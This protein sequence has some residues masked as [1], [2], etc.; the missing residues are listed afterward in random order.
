MD[1]IEKTGFSSEVALSPHAT[2]QVQRTAVDDAARFDAGTLSP[3]E[4]TQT[5]VMV[6]EAVTGLQYGATGE[7]RDNIVDMVN[8]LGLVNPMDGRPI[9]INDDPELIQEAIANRF[10]HS[11]GN[12]RWGNRYQTINFGNQ[13]RTGGPTTTSTTSDK[14][15]KKDIIYVGSTHSGIRLYRFRYLWSEIE[16][17]GVMA[18]ELIHTHP[19]A[20]MKDAWGY[21]KV[22]YAKLDLTFMTYDEWR[23]EPMT[24]KELK[25]TQTTE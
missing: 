21:Y 7:A 3:E 22:D 16:Y 17:V 13:K 20:V 2:K 18:Q 25:K 10:G 5:A 1:S 24:I 14:R 15:L 19:D 9:T 4:A 11:T 8:G 6:S 23:K 12:G